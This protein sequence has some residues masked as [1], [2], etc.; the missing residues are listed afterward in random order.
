MRLIPAGLELTWAV[1]LKFL[2]AADRWSRNE[3]YWLKS[4]CFVTTGPRSFMALCTSLSALFA[5]NTETDDSYLVSLRPQEGSAR[6]AGYT[7]EVCFHDQQNRKKSQPRFHFWD[8]GLWG[9]QCIWQWLLTWERRCIQG[10]RG[11]TSGAPAWP[12]GTICCEPA[13]DCDAYPDPNSV[14]KLYPSP[15]MSCTPVSTVMGFC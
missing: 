6:E 9:V 2:L 13:M 11:R 1:L 15:V 12:L 3:I 14:A 10:D 4:C 7:A 5:D 8:P